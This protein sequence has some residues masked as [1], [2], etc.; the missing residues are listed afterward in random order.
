ME[1]ETFI[2]S[3][4]Q[5]NPTKYGIKAYILA[6]STSGYCW[7]MDIYH[8]QKKAVKKTVE[9]LLTHTCKGLWHLLYMDNYYNSV[10]VSEALLAQKIHTIRTM[11][12]H[13]GEPPKIWLDII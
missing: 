10:E 5:E 11:R 7:N 8:Q 9:G 13:S 6:D 2:L 1:G 4:Q 12:C 3:L